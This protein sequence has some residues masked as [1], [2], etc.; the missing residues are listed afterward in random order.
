M[1]S[2]SQNNHTNYFD[3]REKL[4]P[5][6]KFNEWEMKGVP[7][8]IEVGLRDMEKNNLIF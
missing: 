8:R 2:L 6:Y 3:D 7:I 4:S 1:Q 5:G